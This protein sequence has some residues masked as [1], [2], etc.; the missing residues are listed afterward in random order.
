MLKLTDIKQKIKQMDGGEFHEFCDA[1]LTKLGYKIKQSY[2]MDSG[3]HKTTKGIPDTY[4]LTVDG[5]YVLAMYTT[6][7]TGNI[8]NKIK[9]DLLDCLTVCFS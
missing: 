8:F 4:F 6:Q 5:R 9:K 2:G 1:Y 7:V 3:T